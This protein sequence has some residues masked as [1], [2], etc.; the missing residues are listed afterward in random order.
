MI[1]GFCCC[2]CL[3]FATGMVR[4]KELASLCGPQ[5][6]ARRLEERGK[7]LNICPEPGKAWGGRAGFRLRGTT[8]L[9]VT[10]LFGQF[11]SPSARALP[12]REGV[13]ILPEAKC[14][15]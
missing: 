13:E 5:P 14:H 9:A 1:W 4:E 8:E 6:P 7:G 10:Y 12:V 3:S 2:C 11:K 15:L